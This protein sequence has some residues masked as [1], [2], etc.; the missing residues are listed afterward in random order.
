[1]PSTM[2]ESRSSIST[3][4]TS[5][6]CFERITERLT[7]GALDSQRL[8]FRCSWICRRSDGRR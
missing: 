7:S 5:A 3:S 1:L 4:P 2:R 8:S 6:C